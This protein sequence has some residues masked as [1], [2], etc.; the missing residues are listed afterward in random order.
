VQKYLLL[1]FAIFFPEFGYPQGSDSVV[2]EPP[3]P[4]ARRIV[5]TFAA[6]VAFV[7]AGLMIQGQNQHIQHFLNQQIDEQGPKAPS[8]V[9]DYTQ[10]APIAVVFALTATHRY[11]EHKFMKQLTLALQSEALMIAMVRPLKYI[12]DE[13]RPDGGSHSFPSGHTAQAFMAATFLHKEFRKKSIWYSVAGYTMATAVGSCRMMSNRHWASDV[14]VGAGVGILSTNLVYLFHK[15][16][17]KQSKFS[18]MNITASPTG[19][20]MSMKL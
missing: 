17:K 12:V 5:N 13:R 18:K 16:K 6:P 1:L 9:S 3:V 19:L 8:N 7:A 15:D 14:L 11:G 4:K 2:I 10:F 20:Y